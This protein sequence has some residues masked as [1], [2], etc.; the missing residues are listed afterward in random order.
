[1]PFTPM[2]GSAYGAGRQPFA[3][4]QNLPTPVPSDG[5]RKIISFFPSFN[6]QVEAMKKP[7]RAN[8]LLSENI[9]TRQLHTLEPSARQEDPSPLDVS[10][11]SIYSEDNAESIFSCRRNS[12]ADTFARVISPLAQEDISISVKPG[13]L[14]RVRT[15]NRIAGLA[16][17]ERRR[18]GELDLPI[19][20]VESLQHLAVLI[21]KRREAA[22][23]FHKF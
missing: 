9:D 5:F 23:K 11:A 15:V 7:V 22:E 19:L 10:M 8:T 21:R 13:S 14:K 1:M 6:S 17:K 2:L 18:K 20:P 12:I 4:I 16:M 3:S